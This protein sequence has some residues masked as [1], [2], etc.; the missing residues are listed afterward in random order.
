MADLYGPVLSTDQLH[1]LRCQQHPCTSHCPPDPHMLHGVQVLCRG[2]RDPKQHIE[3]SALLGLSRPALVFHLL[4]SASCLPRHHCSPLGQIGNRIGYYVLARAAAAAS[5]LVFVDARPACKRPAHAVALMPNVVMPAAPGR[6]LNVSQAFAAAAAVTCVAGERT[7]LAHKSAAWLPVADRFRVELQ[8]GL[9]AY[10]K[11]ELARRSDQQ[12]RR[13]L[14]RRRDPH[15]DDESALDDVAIHVR[16]GDVLKR[17]NEEY[18]LLNLRTLSAAIPRQRPRQ[19]AARLTVGIV[20]LPYG[21]QCAKCNRWMGVTGGRP[22]RCPY[23]THFDTP[24]ACT[25]KAIVGHI[26]QRLGQLRPDLGRIH[27][28]DADSPL[29]AWARLALA[30]VATFCISSTF[31]MW[32]TL[33]SEGRGFIV[34]SPVW[35]H[36]STLASTSLHAIKGHEA[37]ATGGYREHELSNPSDR[38]PRLPHLTVINSGFVSYAELRGRRSDGRLRERPGWAGNCTVTPDRVR[39]WMQVSLGG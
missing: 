38:Y 34:A 12:A 1:Q 9:R 5:G 23:G 32:P 18:G 6:Q 2:L 37:T 13:G 26:I 20:T 24:C 3:D 14:L 7:T 33:A 17:Q 19:G 30:P 15:A 28:R 21:K 16:C 10:W 11:D 8:H 27:A 36:A 22:H 31:C 39:H 25:C 35:P 4:P 29:G